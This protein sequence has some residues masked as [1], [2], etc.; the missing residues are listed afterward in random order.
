MLKTSSKNG[1]EYSDVF[2]LIYL[3]IKLE[4]TKKISGVKHLLIDE[5]H[6]YTPVQYAVLSLVF[7]C[8]KTILGDAS[9]SLGIICKTQKQAIHIHHQLLKEFP[10]I[11]L[12]SDESAAF[13]AGVIVC[14]GHMWSF[15]TTK[16]FG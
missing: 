5:M 6:D 14:S 1:Y 13:S 16:H 10:E 9:H 7:P 12:L 15:I 4:G 11:V 8:K 2:S 3:K